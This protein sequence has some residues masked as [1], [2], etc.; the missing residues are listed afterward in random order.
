[1][2]A[3]ILLESTPALTVDVTRAHWLL[4]GEAVVSACVPVK[5]LHIN[6]E[7]LLAANFPYLTDPLSAIQTYIKNN[8]LTTVV[9]SVLNDFDYASVNQSASQANICLVFANA[10][11]GEG[12]ITVSTNVGDRNV[13][14]ISVTVGRH[15]HIL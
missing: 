5:R 15:L 3:P 10:D 11:S 2:Q 4:G 7:Q 1:M 14:F 9:Q 8:S 12:Y 13:C 6:S